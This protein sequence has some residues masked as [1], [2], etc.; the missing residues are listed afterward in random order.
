VKVRRSEPSSPSTQI[1]VVLRPGRG[2]GSGGGGDGNSDTRRHLVVVFP[3]LLPRVAML[4]IV[5][6]QLH[7]AVV[8]ARPIGAS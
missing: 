2:G 3:R 4:E 7:A 6:R 8:V 1:A 5:V